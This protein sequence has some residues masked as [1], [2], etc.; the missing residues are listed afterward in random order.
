MEALQK[1]FEEEKD[2]TFEITADMTRQYKAMQ[3]ELLARIN[4]L[5]NTINDL[6]DKLGALHCWRW[7]RALR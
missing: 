5:E 4:Q 2:S 7:P 6:K 3:E 1:D